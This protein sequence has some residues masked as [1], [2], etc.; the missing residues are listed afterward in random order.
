MANIIQSGSQPIIIPRA[1][2]GKS[3]SGPSSPE[4]KFSSSPEKKIKSI[5]EERKKEA[6][7]PFNVALFSSKENAVESDHYF[8]NPVSALLHPET[9]QSENSGLREKKYKVVTK[10][11][12]K[13]E[14]YKNFRNERKDIERK[15]LNKELTIDKNEIIDNDKRNE[16]IETIENEKKIFNKLKESY[17]VNKINNL[18]KNAHDETPFDALNL[19]NLIP[20]GLEEAYNTLMQQLKSLKP[21]IFP[22]T[23]QEF[24][25]FSN[26]DAKVIRH[27]LSYIN[28]RKSKLPTDF[29]DVHKA[30]IA[31]RLE[32]YWT[33]KKLLH[34]TVQTDKNKN[35]KEITTETTIKEILE[36]HY[37]SQNQKEA[38]T[39][40][41][42]KENKVYPDNLIYKIGTPIVGYL[43]KMV[44]DEIQK[45]KKGPEEYTKTF[46]EVCNSADLKNYFEENYSSS[47][48]SPFKTLLKEEKQHS[49]ARFYNLINY[50]TAVSNTIF[51]LSQICKN[52][53]GL[54]ENKVF[55]V[56][57]KIF[58]NAYAK[59]DLRSLDP[60]LHR[61]DY[62]M[63][64]EK[65][66]LS[67]VDNALL[68][69][70]L[71]NLLDPEVRELQ[72]AHTLPFP[73][74]F[75]W[76]EEKIL[77]Y[78]QEVF[79]TEEAKQLVPDVKIPPL[80]KEIYQTIGK[81]CIDH[82]VI[83]EVFKNEFV[84]SSYTSGE[85]FLYESLQAV[86]KFYLR[87]FSETEL[88]PDFINK[89]LD[90]LSEFK[91]NDVHYKKQ[92]AA[93][94]KEMIDKKR[95][96]SKQ[97]TS[98]LLKPY[99]KET[100]SQIEKAKNQPEYK[101]K[102]GEDYTSSVLFKSACLHR[103]EEAIRAVLLYNDENVAREIFPTNNKI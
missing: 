62:I 81:K 48:E 61:E 85:Q 54:D 93:L 35:K 2:K 32:E 75:A 63:G 6:K 22:N 44:Q 20:N 73:T 86:A 36:S 21:F 15:F 42:L 14:D 64:Y 103:I 96:L 1:E 9:A 26:M 38:P 92:L 94:L 90:G 52:K 45:R 71:N 67:K 8:V 60:E 16:I 70:R 47:L 58:E 17:L 56:V 102:R 39:T 43:F 91:T 59:D 53:Y 65:E 23:L 101:N 37:S 24:V 46:R 18:I 84:N 74:C 33:N 41:I 40:G 28:E 79:A 88:M 19:P 4:K 78:I 12:K 76:K 99:F 25:D 95:L 82:T 31:N 50:Y 77:A 100:A 66:P 55:E 72:R 97:E 89:K 29:W 11:A 68:I 10:H 27:K 80:N 51:H 3:V 49:L 83:E 30:L 98:A 13:D 57:D 87:L 5:L 7:Q 34:T 69:S